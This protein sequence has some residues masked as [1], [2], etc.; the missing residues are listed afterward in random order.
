MTLA[1]E[2]ANRSGQSAMMG[3]RSIWERSIRNR[4][5][6]CIQHASFL[7]R[8]SP[9]GRVYTV[10]V[11]Q[12]NNTC[13]SRSVGA[14]RRSYHRMS[15]S[16]DTQMVQDNEDDSPLLLVGKGREMSLSIGG[17]DLVHG[18]A[19]RTYRLTNGVARVT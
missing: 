8:W 9:E 1:R 10:V 12:H 19:Q 16:P 17:L 18:V 4:V 14:P 5:M 3:S 15:E 13:A 11:V 6:C 2:R 7:R